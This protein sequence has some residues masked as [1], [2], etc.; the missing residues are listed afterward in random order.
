LSPENEKSNKDNNGIL[1]PVIDFEISQSVNNILPDKILLKSNNGN[2]AE[3]SIAGEKAY[4]TIVSSSV[5]QYVIYVM[6]GSRTYVLTTIDNTVQPGLDPQNPM[7]SL[8]VKN[9]I[10]SFKF[11]PVK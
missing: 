2:V 5:N 7:I 1:P 10:S 4:A 8:V 3:I 6:H 9:I 11:T